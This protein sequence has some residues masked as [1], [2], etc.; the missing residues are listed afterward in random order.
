M[1]NTHILPDGFEY[2][3][4]RTVEEALH[5]LATCG[6]GAKIIAGGTDLLVEMK[7]GKV[8][9][10]C[11]VNI[12]RI[13]ALRYLI[14]ERGLRI[15]T[16][17]SFREIERS[18]KIR[19]EYTALYEAAHSVTSVQIKHMGTIGGNLCHA[20]PAADS[21][22][23]FIALGGKARLV[24]GDKARVLPLED[25]FVGPGKTVL[26]P[27]ELF[28]EVQ[29]PEVPHGTGSSFL[30]L[31]RVSADLAKASVAVMVIR[32]RDICKECR[33]VMGA[34]AD[35]PMRATGTEKILIG[36]KWSRPLREKAG[37]KVSEE[38]RPI[39]DV[40]S[41]LWYRKEVSKVL[42]R[43]ALELAWERAGGKT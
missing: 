36:E 24:L 23:P 29:L 43:D 7:M 10:G 14:E 1:I 40:R 27:H 28:V 33:I 11:L 32:E 39:D 12:F 34:V 31:G 4:P 3:E 35:K 41:T 21:A 19:R 30:K 26:F 18:P 9:P 42:L 37:E 8:Q 6:K 38:I 17:T 20:S 13:P 25:F 16:L 15:G 22:P 5:T 2:F